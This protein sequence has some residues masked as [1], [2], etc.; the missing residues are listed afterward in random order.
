MKIGILSDTHDRATATTAALDQFRAAG[1]ELLLHCGDI[2]S[3]DTVRLFAGWPVQ[4]VLGNCD[5]N[6]EGIRY[7]VAEI[8]ATLHDTHGELELAGTKIAWTHGHHRGLFQSLEE[9]DRYDYLFY[10]HSHV[11]EQHRTG[12]TLVVNPGALHRAAVKTCV[13]L[14]L[15]SGEMQSIVVG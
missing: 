6:P 9:A 12:R 10:G 8:G 15:G 4:F 14:E 11:A 5:W 1:V 13:V 2:E 3:S 7:A